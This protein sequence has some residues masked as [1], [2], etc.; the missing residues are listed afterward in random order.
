TS[1]FIA[2]Q[3]GT[4]NFSAWRNGPAL[5]EA[6][7]N[8]AAVFLNGV[9]YVLGGSDASGAP[10]DSTFVATV[11][12][13]TGEIGD[14]RLA[15]DAQLPLAL[16]AAR[17]GLAVVPAPDG[18]IAV[19]GSDTNGPTTSVWK[20]TLD[21]AGKP[22]AWAVQAPLARPQ[23]DAGAFLNGNFLWLVGGTDAN[24][25][26]GAVQRGEIGTA[27]DDLGKVVRWGLRDGPPNLPVARSD[28]A[29]FAAN[30]VFYVAGGTDG[31][32]PKSELYWAT[33]DS[34]G[35]IPEWK[36][37]PQSDLPTAGLAGSAALVSGANAF[38]I[39]GQTSTQVNA[40]SLRTNL[41]PQPP[42]FQLGLVGATVP[43]LKIEGEIGQQLGYLNAAAVGTIDF[44]IL[45]LIGWAFAHKEQSLAMWRRL[46]RRS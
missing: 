3:A 32:S 23:S 34:R 7:T 17:T 37:L 14:W 5:P 40:Q 15:A 21:K 31:T 33:P 42:F 39:G 28:A 13:A 16:P 4:G 9:V 26:S 44:V 30:G 38:L 43:A 25:A 46:R 6:R 19:G 36:H 22:G 2:D 41:A 8:A 10:T 24:G 29:T 11:D 45:V 18:I 35:E 12:A 27:G 1:V 20:S